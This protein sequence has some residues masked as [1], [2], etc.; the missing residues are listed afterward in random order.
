MKRNYRLDSVRDD[1]LR[2]LRMRQPPNV[3]GRIPNVPAMQNLLNQMN[4][5]MNAP[6]H[7]YTDDMNLDRLSPAKF[8]LLSQMGVYSDFCVDTYSLIN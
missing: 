2:K 6:E 4:G 3:T 7:S 8:I 1:I 5:D